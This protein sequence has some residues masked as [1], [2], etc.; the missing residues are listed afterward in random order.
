[1]VCRSQIYDGFAHFAAS[2]NAQAST[3]MPMF[4]LYC[5]DSGTHAESNVAIAGC[6]IATVEQWKEVQRNWDEVN[7]KEKF[8][9]FHMAD[10]VARKEQFALAEWQDQAKR[11]R[12][13]EKLI[14]VITTRIEFGIAA[15][16]LKSDYDAVVPSDIRSRLGKNHYTFAIKMCVAY[17]EKWR[18]ERGY[19]EPMQYVFDQLSKGKG[20]INDAFNVVASG[21][22]DA[23]RRYGVCEDGWSFQSKSVVTQLQTADIWAYE[24]YRYAA[25]RF[26]PPID[27]RRGLR[28]SYR[29]LRTKIPRAIVRY[30]NQKSLLELVS[31]IREMGNVQQS[32][33]LTPEEPTL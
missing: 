24:N 7:E 19:V 32:I 27:Q 2:I 28:E 22:P 33:I 3:V 10:F 23:I 1:V 4:T 9:V 15:A 12:T 17:L 29:I 5:D 8:G 31:R 21:G 16:V 30:L 18:E 11:N 26:F 20:D 25:N 14:N 6:C 13:L